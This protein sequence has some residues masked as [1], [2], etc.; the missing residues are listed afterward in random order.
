MRAV[1]YARYSSENQREASIEDQ[2]RN[3]ERRAEQEKWT[4]IQRYADKGISGSKDGDQRP[5]YKALLADAKEKRFD[6]LLVEDLSRLSRDEAELI[7]TRRKLIFWKVRLV[8]VSDG[9]DSDAKGHKIQATVRGLMN[10]I[11]LDDLKDKTHRG[12]AGRAIKG[13]NCGGRTYGYKHVPICHPNEKDEYGRPRIIAAKREI[14]E[15]QARW[16]QEI[17][18]WYADGKSPRWIAGELNRLG[19]PGPA[20]GYK[21]KKRRS[22]RYGTWSASALHG[23][24]KKYTGLLNNPLYAG[25]L[26]W[27]RREWLKNPETK[28]KVPRLRPESEWIIKECP[29]LR[30]VSD[31]VWKRVQTRRRAPLDFQGNGK[32]R[33]RRGPKYLLSGLLKCGVCESNYVISSYY[34]YG[35]AGYLNRGEAHCANR[36]RVAR[37]LVEERCLAAIQRDLFTAEALDLFVKETT[38]LLAER[39]RTQGSE[40]AL[41]QRRLAKVEQEIQNI[42]VAIKAGVL[43]PTTKEEL[44]KA[45]AE[46]AGLLEM[47]KADNRGLGKVTT[48]LPRAAERYRALVAN[49]ANLPERQIATARQQIRDLLGGGIKLV[50]TTDGYLEAEL[51]GDYAGLLKLAAGTKLNYMVA[52]EG[53][54]PS[55]FGLCVP[56]QLSLPG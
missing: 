3:C 46:R 42:M 11:Y 52:G 49:L 19:V 50:P 23:D 24:P 13:Y 4:I 12:L 28:C 31:D 14:D 30:I 1:I 44:E 35:C 40:V 38:R 48:F 20:A 6:V 8:G 54:E 32:L 34:Q 51:V 21:R 10:E 7:L 39:Q 9:F 17:F 16:V 43:T 25:R 15:A 26:V 22:V 56:L 33:A 53:F 45:E 27:N 5:G 55:T 47:V 29:E 2:Y 41:T 18:T 36:L 37:T